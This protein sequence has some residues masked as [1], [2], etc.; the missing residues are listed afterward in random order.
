MYLFAEVPRRK[1]VPV[2]TDRCR[3]P[4]RIC[5]DAE[6][7]VRQIK[8]LLFLLEGLILF[9]R[10]GRQKPNFHS[11]NT[12]LHTLK[13][14]LQRHTLMLSRRSAYTCVGPDWLPAPLRRQ[15]ALSGWLHPA[16]SQMFCG[17]L[18]KPTCICLLAFQNVWYHCIHYG[19]S[20]WP[21]APHVLLAGI[22]V[23]KGRESLL[24]RK[25]RIS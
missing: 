6:E 13:P 15:S 2:V 9:V 1:P 16:S 11:C 4:R 25:T 7:I 3:P 22:S 20:S 10:R 8:E 19:L 5:R 18:C 23:C 12:L 24:K 14:P 21:P 17:L